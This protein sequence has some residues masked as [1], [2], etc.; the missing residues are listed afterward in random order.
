[1]M[2]TIDLTK[3]KFLLRDLKVIESELI[4]LNKVDSTI[5][6][7]V[8]ALEAFINS[9]QSVNS[10]S[11]KGIVTIAYEVSKSYSKETKDLTSSLDRI[12]EEIDYLVLSQ[13]LVPAQ[14]DLI[15]KVEEFYKLATG[16][17]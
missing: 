10:E 14:A 13:S 15:R 4:K 2:S 9:P 7:V 6:R 8:N 17:K 5:Q 12:L 11:I 1:M 3:S 16:Q